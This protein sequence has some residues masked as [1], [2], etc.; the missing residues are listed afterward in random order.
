MDVIWI[1]STQ[2]PKEDSTALPQL[3]ILPSSHQVGEI[4]T[5]VVLDVSTFVIIK[6]ATSRIFLQKA[7]TNSSGS[8]KTLLGSGFF[9]G[10]DRR[11]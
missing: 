1:K 4:D 6:I 7:P 2:H 5:L 3:S 9:W 10:Q 11:L 8:Q